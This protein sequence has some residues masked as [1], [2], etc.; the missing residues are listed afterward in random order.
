MT[1][2]ESFELEKSLIPLFRTKYIITLE[3][4]LIDPK[5]FNLKAVPGK[6]YKIFKPVFVQEKHELACL[7]SVDYPVIYDHMIAV[8]VEALDVVGDEYLFIRAYRV[9]HT[10]QNDALLVVVEAQ[11][12]GGCHIIDDDGR[13]GGEGRGHWYGVWCP[14]EALPELTSDLETEE[15]RRR[16]LLPKRYYRLCPESE[17]EV[18]TSELPPQEQSELPLQ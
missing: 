1:G 4:E 10:P 11:V 9:G 12:K 17:R 7:L 16:E 8:R 3:D 6:S 18:D 5:G 13:I 2:T 15:T 14:I